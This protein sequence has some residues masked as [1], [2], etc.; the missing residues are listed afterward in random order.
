MNECE[1]VDKK[2]SLEKQWVDLIRRAS[3]ASGIKARLSDA[4]RAPYPTYGS[5]LQ[6]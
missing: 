3:V 6:A 4:A 5:D 2:L 1:K